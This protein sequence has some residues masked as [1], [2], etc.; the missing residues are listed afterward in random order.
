MQSEQLMFCLVT[1]VSQVA[2]EVA[3]ALELPDFHPTVTRVIPP[4]SL[5]P[6]TGALP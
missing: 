4:A 2:A 3:F 5:A 1:A 6:L